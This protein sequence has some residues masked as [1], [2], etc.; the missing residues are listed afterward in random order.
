MLYINLTLFCFPI[1]GKNREG[2]NR[3]KGKRR[4]KKPFSLWDPPE[5]QTEASQGLETLS[6]FDLPVNCFKF[7]FQIAQESQ[8]STQGRGWQ[9]F[10]DQPLEYLTML[11]TSVQEIEK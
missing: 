7:V 9:L 11:S 5:H 2:K 10:K 8:G 6:D 1:I 4:G 3:E